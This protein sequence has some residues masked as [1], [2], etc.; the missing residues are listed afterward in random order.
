MEESGI[1]K[2]CIGLIMQKVEVEEFW[3]KLLTTGAYTML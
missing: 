2:K 1:N 3:I